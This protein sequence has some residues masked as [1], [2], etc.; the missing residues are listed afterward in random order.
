MNKRTCA[1][2]PLLRAPRLGERAMKPPCPRCG[3]P[4]PGFGS[5][6]DDSGGYWRVAIVCQACG[7]VAVGPVIPPYTERDGW[8][9]PK[10]EARNAAVLAVWTGAELPV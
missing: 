2:L 5:Q 1:N 3:N 8:T 7:H 6:C 4:W 10:I 9:I